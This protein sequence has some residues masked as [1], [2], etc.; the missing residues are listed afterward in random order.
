[1]LQIRINSNPTQLA[2]NI[3]NAQLNLQTTPSKV[4]IKT[5]PPSLEISQPR[6]ELMIDNTPFYYS[7]GLKNISDFAQDNAA[8]ARQA[9]INTIARTVAEGNRLAQISNP[10]NAIAEN[11]TQATISKPVEI[12]WAHL[13]APNIQYKANPAQIEVS[14]G[15]V[16]YNSQPGT[17]NGD[18]QPGKVAIRVMQ[19]PSIELTTV[20]V[21][22]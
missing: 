12:T 5:V 9:L 19:Y 3:Q 17:V 13:A 2:Y 6:G 16:N 21:K 8:H 20:D 7:I 1:M 11:A 4:M 10:S 22:V 15:K 14:R 18:Y